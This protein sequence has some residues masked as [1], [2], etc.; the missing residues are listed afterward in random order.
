MN[1][2]IKRQKVADK[3]ENKTQ[4]NA[5]SRTLSSK[6]KCKLR[7]EGMKDDTPSKWEPNKANVAILISNKNK[8]Q[9][10]KHYKRQNGHYIMIKGTIHQEDLIVFHMLC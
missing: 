1:P 8:L 9:A 5:A 3:F 4:L 7:S 6:D 10:K 2:R